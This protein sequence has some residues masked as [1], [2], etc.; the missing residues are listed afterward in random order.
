MTPGQVAEWMLSELERSDFLD[1]GVAVFHIKENFGKEFVYE[2][3]A[4]NLAISRKVLDEFKKRTKDTIVW[5]RGQ[6]HWRKRQNY[7]PKN[8]RQ[9]D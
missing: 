1:Q 9:A 3:E 2:N 7:D 4:G 5:D 6:R 8:K